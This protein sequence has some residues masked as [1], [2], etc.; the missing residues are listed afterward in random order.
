MSSSS[1]V[2]GTADASS[3]LNINMSNVTKLTATNYLMWKRQVH[4]LCKGYD[5]A[6]YLDGSVAAPDATVTTADGSTANLAYKHWMRQ[7]QLILSSLLGAISLSVQPLLST[8]A[9]SAEIWRTLADTYAKPSRTHVKQIREQLKHW[10]KASRSIEEY[11]QGFTTRFDQLA[12][13]DNPIAQEDQIDYILGGLPDEYK[14]VVD[15]IE[16]RDTTPSLTVVLEK[17]INQELKLQT[18]LTVSSPVPVSANVASHRSNNNRN[19]HQSR[20][21]SSWQSRQQSQG[22]DRGSNGHGYQGRCQLCGTHG[23]SARWC[24]QLHSSGRGF[25]SSGGNYQAS[26]MSPWQP[27]ANMPYNGGEDVTIADG[28]SLKIANTGSGEG[29]QHGDPVTPGQD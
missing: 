4:A 13:L 10:K 20:G 9:T 5:L 12:L 16:G 15:Q 19:S 3:L 8:A 7:D 17:L 2:I 28:S 26:P 22:R 23:H 11:F 18:L 29:S 27:Q 1:E 21:G 24:T 25:A 6:G 14:Q